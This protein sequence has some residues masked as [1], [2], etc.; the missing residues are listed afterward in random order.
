LEFEPVENKAIKLQTRHTL[1]PICKNYC[2]TLIENTNIDFYN[3]RYRILG[4]GKSAR[5]VRR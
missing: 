4:S 2:S 5:A 3:Q 1:N